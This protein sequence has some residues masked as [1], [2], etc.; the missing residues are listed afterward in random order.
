M[1]SFNRIN[2]LLFKTNQL[3]STFHNCAGAYIFK[4][5]FLLAQNIFRW[6]FTRFPPYLVKI[7]WKFVYIWR[8]KNQKH[9][10]FPISHF[11][12]FPIS[13]V[14]LY[15][16]LPFLTFES[17][18]KRSICVEKATH[19]S[20]NMRPKLKMSTCNSRWK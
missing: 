18:R 4:H 9:L 2:R 14:I 20:R 12:L 17:S 3:F 7:I 5:S 13:P 15:H 8:K 16:S 6:Y 10:L 19:S 11:F 1:C